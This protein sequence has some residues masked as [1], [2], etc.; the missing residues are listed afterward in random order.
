MRPIKAVKG[1]KGSC[2]I[3]VMRSVQQKDIRPVNIYAANFGASKYS[4]V[5]VPKLNSFHNSRLQTELDENQIKFNGQVQCGPYRKFDC[6]QFRLR[7]ESW[8]L[9][10]NRSDNYIKSVKLCY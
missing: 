7:P 9:L 3:M 2:N 5:S 8:N 10:E 4:G 6:V 1:E